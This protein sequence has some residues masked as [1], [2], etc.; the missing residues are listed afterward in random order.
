MA[1]HREKPQREPSRGDA[2][3][4]E[5]RQLSIESGRSSPRRATV[6]TVGVEFYMARCRR[7]NEEDDT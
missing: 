3:D 5:A 2:L 6:L 1:K 7:L 4:V